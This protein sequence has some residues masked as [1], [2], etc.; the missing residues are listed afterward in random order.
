[1]LH[2]SLIFIVLS[3]LLYTSCNEDSFS[4]VVNIDPPVFDKQMTLHL[5]LSDTDSLNVVQ[6]GQN[7]G[8]LES[9]P[10]Q[11]WFLSGGN[12]EIFENNQ[13]ILKYDESNDLG[14]ISYNTLVPIGL[15]QAGKKYELKAT[16]PSFE[17]VTATQIMPSLLVIDSVRFRANA[18]IS[19]DPDGSKLEA[20]DVFIKDKAG[21]ENYYEMSVL[22]LYPQ[23]E[24]S[25]DTINGVPIYV[26]D[27]TGYYENTAYPDSPEDPNALTGAG[28]TLL[29]SDK[30]FDGQKYKFSFRKY[31]NSNIKQFT[32]NVRSIT[33]DAY[34][35]SISAKR[36]S[37]AEDNPLS[38]PVNTYSNLTG[39]IGVFALKTEKKFKIE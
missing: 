28:N 26:I 10:S 3:S 6:L 32:V 35:Y 13:S 16:H 1:M 11:N 31:P 36:K 38:E 12:I 34:L 21:E 37:D 22:S 24:Y 4:Q 17:S 15:L 9:V 20:I 29:I 25:L 27:T 5:F 33:Q 18:G 14:N 39:G 19:N 2:K 8:I 23:I 7:F 30:F